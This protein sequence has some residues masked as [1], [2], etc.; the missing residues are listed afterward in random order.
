MIR[1]EVEYKDLVSWINKQT[2]PTFRWERLQSKGP[3]RFEIRLK[4]QRDLQEI[5]S[6]DG[7]SLNGRR[8]SVGGQGSGG[9]GSS[10]SQRPRGRPLDD[11]A[12]RAVG[13]F[14]Q[15]AA[16]NSPPKT[17]KLEQMASQHRSFDF[18]NTHFVREMANLIK[19]N[20]PDVEKILLSSN[21]IHRL[22]P[23]E[24][25]AKALTKL[26]HLSLANN[27]ISNLE[28]IRYLRELRQTLEHLDC[29]GCPFLT[30]MKAEIIL[31]AAKETLPNLLTFNG[32]PATDVISF[33]MPSS[34]IKGV[35]P[36]PKGA[37]YSD[38]KTKNIT[39]AFIKSYI[40]IFDD[41]SRREYL[42]QFYLHHS[43]LS[44]SYAPSQN[45]QRYQ[46]GQN[47]NIVQGRVTIPEISQRLICGKSE[48]VTTLKKLP[49]MQHDLS[50]FVPDATMHSNT[51]TRLTM[52]N[53]NLR[54]TYWESKSQNDGQKRYFHR[55]MLL[56]PAPN[57]NPTNTAIANDML[58]LGELVDVN[59]N[60]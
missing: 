18:G 56:A 7:K 49:M 47:R 5:I 42:D 32:V 26:T 28:D 9:F 4:N 27:P 34:L 2:N 44:I 58:Y 31:Y 12:K 33:N 55:V 51:A 8:I 11:N 36:K 29:T 16:K 39:E 41:I 30:E 50:S 46:G 1:A 53:I 59:F 19:S 60:N 17:L 52:I 25:L 37:F 22:S 6:L 13:S 10:G 48:I 43:C 15:N 3:G 24:P 57:A 21:N 40:Q 54:G 23:L 14:L 20:M 45:V 35:T 38:E